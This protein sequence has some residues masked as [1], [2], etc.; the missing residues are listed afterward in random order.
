VYQVKSQLSTSTSNI[1]KGELPD[2][3]S[4]SSSYSPSLPLS[5]LLH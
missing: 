4:Q 2:F 3:I 5:S 1:P